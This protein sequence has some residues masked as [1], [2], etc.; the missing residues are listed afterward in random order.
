MAVGRDAQSRF[1]DQFLTSPIPRLTVAGGTIWTG[2]TGA[3]FSALVVL[4][5][6]RVGGAEP[7]GGLWAVPAIAALACALGACYAALAWIISA[8]ASSRRVAGL[9]TAA[10]LVSTL[11]LSD[12]LLPNGLLPAWLRAMAPVNPLTAAIDG[13]RAVAWPHPEWQRWGRNLGVLC[14]LALAARIVAAALPRPR[15][16]DW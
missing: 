2:A 15:R 13:A 12:L 10:L 6:G 11:L 1:L 4:V 9:V 16:A 3:A 7:S 5:A 14:A 8:L